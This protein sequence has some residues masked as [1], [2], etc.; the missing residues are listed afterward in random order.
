MLKS[1]LQIKLVIVTC[2]LLIGGT[3]SAQVSAIK[4]YHANKRFWQFKGKPVMLLGASK[5]DNLFQIPDLKNHLDLMKSVGANYIRNTMSSRDLDKVQPFVRRSDGK[6]DLNQWNPEYWNRFENMLRLTSERDIIVQIEVWAFH[7]FWDKSG[8]F[9]TATNPWNPRNN[10]NY[11]TSNT[12]IKETDYGNH[13]ASYV[14]HDFFETV[15]KVQNDVN[16]L[17][18]QQKF[19]DKILSHTLKYEHVLYC[20]TNEIFTQYSP[21][22]GWYWSDYIKSKAQQAGETVQVAE[23][24]QNHDL[25][26]QQHR[27]SFDHPEIFDFVDISQNSGAIND[28]HWNKLQWVYNYLNK[29]PRPINHTKTYGSDNHGWTGGDEQAVRRFWRS[30]IGG[31]ASIRFHRPPYGL[32]LNEKAQKHVKSARML[33]EHIDIFRSKPD[34]NHSLISDRGSDEAYLTSINNESYAVYLPYGGTVTLDLSRISGSFEL[35]WLDILGNRWVNKTTVRA[36]SKIQLKS[37][38]SGNPFV[39]LIGGSAPQNPEPEEPTEPSGEVRSIYLNNSK[40]GDEIMQLK[41][42]AEVDLSVTGKDLNIVAKTSGEIGSIVFGLNS[43]QKYYVDNASPFSLAETK[44]WTPKVGSYSLTVSAYDQSNGAGNLIKS[45]KIN[46]KVVDNTPSEPVEAITKIILVNASNKNEIMSLADTTE[47]DLAET[48]TNLNIIANTINSVESMVFGLGDNN[49]YHTESSAPY[50]FAGD[51]GSWSPSVGNYTLKF[52]AY[53]LDNGSGTLMES[54]SIYLKVVDNTVTEPDT[55]DPVEEPDPAGILSPLVNNIDFGTVGVGG[56]KTTDLI[57]EN[58]GDGDLDIKHVEVKGDKDAFTINLQLPLTIQN[59]ANEQAQII[60]TPDQPGTKKAVIY[61]THSG[62]NDTVKVEVKGN[63]TQPD[64]ETPRIALD[65]GGEG[66]DNPYFGSD[67]E[68]DEGT[69]TQTIR[70]IA[71]TDIQ[72]IYQTARFSASLDYAIPVSNGSYQVKLHFAEIYWSTPSRRVFDVYLENKLVLDNLDIFREVGK[73]YALIKEFDVVVNDEAL[74]IQLKKERDNA[75]LSA[76]EIV[77]L[78][79]NHDP[80]IS[81]IEPVSLYEASQ[82]DISFNVADTNDE[83]V[84]IWADN[85]PSFAKLTVNG[86]SGLLTLSP[87]SG[88]I[89]KYD[90]NLKAKDPQGA[91]DSTVIPVE[92]FKK[93]EN[94]VSY[95]INVGGDELSVGN[96]IFSKDDFHN[97]WNVTSTQNPIENTNLDELYQTGR[98]GGRSGD[99]LSYELPL[100]SGSYDVKLHFV[101][102]YWDRGRR[103]MF[104]VYMNGHLVMEDFDIHAEVGKNT[105]F[106][107]SIPVYN[108]GDHLKI[109]LIASVDYAKLAGIEVVT[110][111]QD[112]SKARIGIEDEKVYHELKLYPNPASDRVML[113]LGGFSKNKPVDIKLIDLAGMVRYEDSYIM[114][115]ESKYAIDLTKLNLKRGFYII[116][117]RSEGVYDH[118]KF[119]K[120]F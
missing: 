81:H 13:H 41:E 1:I 113:K 114:E 64:V 32:G 23:M 111:Q 30:I 119:F 110:S 84:E 57:L 45:L 91:M 4:P 102:F 47:I 89:G 82:R 42:N 80:I 11:S 93:S 16:V 106:V 66:I 43:D 56:E 85:L 59:G 26:H 112:Y 88:D 98:F 83:S 63:C 14:I 24:Y 20:I 79:I 51:D 35:K 22:W 37:P 75:I 12:Q 78:D 115:Y 67:V 70:N 44:S 95:N 74:N 99:P 117:V 10:I 25:T 29:S 120:E 103:R 9:W 17:K 40:S 109:D 34:R 6:Y 94:Q 36:G 116:S 118:V 69:K 86:K 33:L 39:A 97:G 77:S 27:A 76:I 68:Y 73:N 49:Q 52:S 96:Q 72:K 107:K 108:E 92:V 50:C 71:N 61:F 87:A 21:E 101:E 31:A 2:L 8:D 19:V 90:I 28:D 53:S 65:V 15:P 54:K 46:F 48:G 5:D 58:S 18:Y 3:L 100:P 7:D 105:A 38:Q 104:D 55:E 62:S 60:F